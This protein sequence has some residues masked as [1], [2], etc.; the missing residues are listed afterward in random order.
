MRD[1]SLFNFINFASRGT[2]IKL[3]LL[4]FSASL[5]V[6]LT[7]VSAATLWQ[8]YKGPTPVDVL[9]DVPR[10]PAATIHEMGSKKNYEITGMSVGFMDKK[11]HRLSHAQFSL[12]FHCP[13]EACNKNLLLNHAKVLDIIFEVSSDFYIEDF[14]YPEAEKGFLRFKNKITKE[15]EKK[16]AVMAPKGVVIQDWFMN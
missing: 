16:F 6:T 14:L 10:Q 2:K 7:L 13:D 3:G 11:E 5:I 1:S 12:V 4:F 9:V 15:M 8:C